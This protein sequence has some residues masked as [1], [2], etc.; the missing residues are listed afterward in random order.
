MPFR[1]YNELMGLAKESLN[2]DTSEA[3]EGV[4]SPELVDRGSETEPEV[5]VLVAKL[6]ELLKRLLPANI[7]TL[8][9]IVQHLCRWDSTKTKKSKT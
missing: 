8:K 9:Y 1:I 7:A 4:K 3:S 6:R 2:S 5:L